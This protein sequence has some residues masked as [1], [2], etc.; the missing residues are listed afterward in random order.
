MDI[1]DVRAKIKKVQNGEGPMWDRFPVSMRGQLAQDV[2]QDRKF[3]LGME[4]GYLYA[5]V[6]HLT[7][8]GFRPSLLTEFEP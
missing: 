5:L 7:E 2:W 6:E 3:R 8:R 1:E 4:Y